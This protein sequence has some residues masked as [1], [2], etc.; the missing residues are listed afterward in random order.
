MLRLSTIFARA[1]LV[2]TPL[3]AFAFAGCESPYPIAPTA[4]D[5][6]CIA[7]E[8]AGCDDDNPFECVDACEEDLRPSFA[9][10]ESGWH[11]LTACYRTAPNSAFFCQLGRSRPG[12]V[13]EAEV[14][15][16]VTCVA[17]GEPRCVAECLRR[18]AECGQR[19]WGCAENCKAV[20]A[21]CSAASEAMYQ[22]YASAPITCPRDRD[23]AKVPVEDDQCFTQILE[24]LACTG[25]PKG[26]AGI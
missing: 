24:Y 19:P 16:L 13:C 7:I 6:W 17:G 26:D 1:C 10:C 18:A 15:E 2:V 9:G 5:D 11:A 4:C 21:A 20:P 12:L 23:P 14:D 25:F 22:C 3:V 8:R